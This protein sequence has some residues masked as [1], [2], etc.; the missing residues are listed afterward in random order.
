MTDTGVSPVLFYD[1]VER[2][3]AT[4]HPNHTYEKVVFDPWQQTTYDVNDTVAARRRDVP[5][6][7]S[8]H[9][10]GHRRLRAASTSRPSRPTGQ[11]WYAQRIGGAIGHGRAGRRDEGRSTRRHADRRAPRH[12]GPPVHDASRT[13]GSSAAARSHEERY[14]TRIELDIEGNQ[15]AVATPSYERADALEQRV[16]MRYDYDLLGNRIHQASMEAGERWMLNDVTGKPIRAW[17]SRRFMRRM[18]Y[19]E[20]RRPTGLYVTD[21]NGAERLAERTV[22]GESQGDA[23]QPPHPRL[24][25]L[26]RRRR[27]HQRRPTTSRATSAESQAR[28]AARLQGAAAELAAEPARERRQ[29]HDAARRT[30]R[31]TAP[32]RSTV[33]RR[34]RLSCRPSTRPT[35]ST[36]WT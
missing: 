17:D 29:L 34:Q 16:V 14:A 3:V 32:S 30:T 15:R 18:T 4:L 22:Y 21:G 36:R 33:A 24:P 6:R 8:A 9:R 12:A 5:D 7:R 2:V 26:R 23:A 31:S 19:D 1:P 11:T 28:A 10:S 13:T 20:L 27:R 25:G 35:C